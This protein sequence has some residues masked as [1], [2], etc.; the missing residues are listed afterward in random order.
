M[1]ASAKKYGIFLISTIC[2][3]VALAVA[4]IIIIV[5]SIEVDDRS[6]QMANGLYYL[7]DN[8]ASTIFVVACTLAALGFLVGAMGFTRGIKGIPNEDSPN[9][10]FA[11]ALLGFMY[12]TMGVYYFYRVVIMQ[13]EYSTG[14]KLVVV[15]T[16]VTAAYFLTISSHRIRARLKRYIPL[17]SLLAVIL[18]AARLLYD[19]IDRSLTVTASSYGYHLLGLAALMLFL[20]CEG[21]YI[22][23]CRRKRLYVALGLIAAMLLAVYCIPALFLAL[24]YP[25]QFTDVTLYCVADIITAIY[26]YTRLFSM[27]TEVAEPASEPEEETESEISSTV[28]TAE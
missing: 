2:V 28:V 25:K 4:R 1:S 9:F 22:V 7:D 11:S 23:G 5:N 19:F 6:Y 21:R 8:A 26:I 16:F 18:T 20:C 10:L 27:V 14:F 15:L 3:T 17:L 12:L 24:F 13:A